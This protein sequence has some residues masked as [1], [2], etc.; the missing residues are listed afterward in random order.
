MDLISGQPFWLFKNG[1]LHSYET[2][3]ED[4]KTDVVI[5]GGGITGALTAWHLV[6][7]GFEVIVVEKRH[8]GMGSTSA[9]TA[10]LQY[11]ID[12]MLTDLIQM[13]G[14]KKAVRS[15]LACVEAIYKVQEIVKALRQP[16]GF[17]LK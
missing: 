13:I 17:G 15:Y 3:D 4:L 14:E 16:L 11:E 5:M 12:T 1:I 2:M 9:S 6:N 7:A 10:L 8:I